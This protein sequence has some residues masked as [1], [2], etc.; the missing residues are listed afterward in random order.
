VKIHSDEIENLGGT[1]VGS[2]LG[3]VSADHL[4]MSSEEDLRALKL[5]GTIPV[6]LPGTLLTIFSDRVPPVA[7]MR[8]MGLPIALGTDLNP[9]CMLESMQL[10]QALGCYRLRMTPNEVLAASTVNAAFAI[11]LGDRKGRIA[12][13]YDADMLILKE[14]KFDHV[15][16]HFGANHVG[17]VI[18]GGTVTVRDQGW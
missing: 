5:S 14:D 12:P 1:P 7:M 18:V 3:A 6:L 9:N 17:T 11:G 2:E 13:G 4:L 15:P 16:Y 10:V 8:E